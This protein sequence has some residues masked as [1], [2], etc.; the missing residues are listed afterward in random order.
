MKAKEASLFAV[1]RLFDVAGSEPGG[2]ELISRRLL[3][4][5]FGLRAGKVEVKAAL[6]G[7]H[8]EKAV[9]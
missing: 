9:A 1:G 7:K 4:S 2:S 8:K 3:E 6:E 5:L